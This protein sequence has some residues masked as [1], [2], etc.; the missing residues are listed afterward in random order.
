MILRIA[1][2]PVPL[3]RAF[4]YLPPAD[5]SVGWYRLG[6][7]IKVPFGKQQRIGILLETTAKS[8]PP[9]QGRFC[10]TRRD[11]GSGPERVRRD[12]R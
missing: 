1:I 5:D 7:R 8:S 11:S 6:I 10:I 9:G 4:D 3:R 2:L 12:P